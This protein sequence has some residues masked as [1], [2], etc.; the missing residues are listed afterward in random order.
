MTV[1]APSLLRYK[2]CLYFRMF[3]SHFS[4]ASL[5]SYSACSLPQYIWDFFP[6]VLSTIEIQESMKI[7]YLLWEWNIYAY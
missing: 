5:L 1:S 6:L 7:L 3:A 2:L 4:L